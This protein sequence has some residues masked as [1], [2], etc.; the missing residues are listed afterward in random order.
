MPKDKYMK[1]LD[2]MNDIWLE[3][4]KGISVLEEMGGENVVDIIATGMC[5]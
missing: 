1:I 2:K 3:V 4:M 5:D